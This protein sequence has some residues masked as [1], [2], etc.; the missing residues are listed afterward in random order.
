MLD[1]GKFKLVAVDDSGNIDEAV[2]VQI[3]KMSNG[4][5]IPEDEPIFIVRARDNLAV[6]MLL[7]YSALC[8]YA[9]CTDSQLRSLDTQ[10]NKFMRFRLD[11]PERMKQPGITEGR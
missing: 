11:H 9:L 10:I 2:K 6:P 5:V 7:H 1:D 4:E 8:G 3:V